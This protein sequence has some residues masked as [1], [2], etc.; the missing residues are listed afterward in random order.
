MMRVSWTGKKNNKEIVRTPNYKRKRYIKIRTGQTRFKD[1]T[2]RKK[3]LE[4]LVT[5]GKIV[6][7]RSRGR[8]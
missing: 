2:V 5:T 8:Q 1:H 6:G 3:K 4:H 7:K